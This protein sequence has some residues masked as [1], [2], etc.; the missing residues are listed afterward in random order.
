M[1]TDELDFFNLTKDL[2]KKKKIRKLD[3]ILTAVLIPVPF[4]YSLKT[5]MSSKMKCNGHL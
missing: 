5:E 4:Q 2:K 1:L 3:K